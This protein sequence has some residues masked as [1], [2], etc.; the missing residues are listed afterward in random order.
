M[1]IARPSYVCSRGHW[2]RY[3]LAAALIALL[4]EPAFPQS[5]LDWRFWTAADGLPESFVRKLSKGPDGRIW[6]RNGVVGSMSILDGYSVTRIP[7]PRTNRIIEDWNLMARVHS[8]GDGE[9]WTVE[10]H[11]LKRYKGGQ[12]LVEASET[13]GERMIVAMP[14]GADRVLVLFSGRLS[15]FQPSQRSWTAIKRSEDLSIGKF[16][17]MAP[18]FAGDFWITAAHGIARLQAG[19]GAHDLQWTER[20]T[21][22][23]GLS[24]IEWPAAADNGEVV[25]T[26]RVDGGPLHA[27]ARWKQPLLEIVRTSTSKNLRGWLGPDGIW[28]VDGASLF[29]L[30]DGQKQDVPKH[31]TLSGLVY[32]VITEPGG[33]FWVGTTDGLAHYTPALWRTPEPTMHLDQPVHSIVED[34]RGRL[35]FAATQHLVELDG[36][37]WRFHPLPPGFRTQTVHTDAV[38]PLPDGRIGLMVNEVERF[39]RV[40]IFDPATGR[41]Q[42]LDHPEGRNVVLLTPRRDGTFWA[43]TKPGLRIDIFDGKTFRPRFDFTA[44]WKGDDVRSLMESS[45]GDLWIAGTAGSAVV[46]NGVLKKFGG[47]DGFTDSSRF[48]FAE[49]EPDRILAGGRDDLLEWNGRRWSVLRQGLDRV[50]TITKTRDGVVWVVSGSGVHRLRSDAWI[51]NGEDDGLPSNTA[52]TV[53]Q[54]SKGRIWAG[55]SRGLSLYNPEMDRDYP[56]TRLALVGN[57]REVA[58]DGNIRL[59]FS[60]IDKWKQTLS[61]RLL[62]SYSLDSLP[63]TPF[64]SASVIAFQKLAPKKHIIHVRAM[65]RNGNREPAADSFEFIV[66]LPWFRQAGFILIAGAGC[67]AIAILVGIAIRN[68][69]LRGALIVQ[70]N[71]SRLAAESASRHKSE[72]LA[73]MSH[74]IRTPMNAIMGMTQLALDTSLDAEQRDYL[75]IV[76]TSADS[77][78]TLLNDILDFSKVEAGKLELSSIDFNLRECAAAVLRTLDFR[79]RQNGLK[80]SMRVAEGVPQFLSGDDQRLR[81]ILMNLVG[82]AIKF[83]HSG[84][85]NLEVGLQAEDAASVALHFIVADTGIGIPLEKQKL[86]FAPFEQAD[87][88]ASRKYGGTGLGLAISTKLVGLMRGDCWVESPWRDP[89]T[90]AKVAG[91]AFHFTAHFLPGQ[92]P[93]IVPS[94]LP[95]PSPGKLRILLAEDNLVN[96]RLALRMLEKR[97]HTVL[98]AQDGREALAILVNEPV[99]LVLMDVQMPDLDGFQATAAIRDREKTSGD[100]LPIVALT[101]HALKGDK[102]RCLANGM[103]AYLSKPIRAQDLDRALAE[104]G[105][106]SLPFPRDQR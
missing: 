41:F 71:D 93:L 89:R 95:L 40:L 105:Q 42:R 32:D 11:A 76:S 21:R 92:V 77:L 62:F 94:E 27:I 97:G 100:H 24:E 90:G 64:A 36:S 69:R 49:I 74:E 91:S 2:A 61:D 83:T 72:F 12:W 3:V 103:D 44:D 4:T 96:Q 26:G 68:F 99:D 52:Y 66:D 17:H 9:A 80:L 33:A 38:W 57:S 34:R 25:V 48:V 45:T 104:I 5:K 53:F 7:E 59:F 18:G 37:T 43:W 35:W 67:L 47:S 56:Q 1:T 54:D 88:S 60:G 55:A 20:D 23:I 98:V 6:I 29:R 14:A 86:I 22:A 82:N 58:P 102:E 75:G 8:G 73:N 28:G 15:A 78:L 19:P 30:V 70:L 84:E 16:L 51:T 85:I 50:R 87:G 46:R 63:W 65:D 101:A 79:C 81:Q 10:N 31:G 39:D 106:A 13:P